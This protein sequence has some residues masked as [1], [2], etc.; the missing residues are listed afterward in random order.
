[1]KLSREEKDIL[2]NL[3]K[4]EMEY[5]GDE[6]DNSPYYEESLDKEWCKLFEIKKKL[7]K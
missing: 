3:L 7:E 4:H 5:I 2:I 6:M 1:M